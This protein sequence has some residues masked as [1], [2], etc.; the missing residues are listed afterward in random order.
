M[1]SIFESVKNLPVFLT[2]IVPGYITVTVFRYILFNDKDQHKKLSTAIM[3][4]IV[5]SFLIKSIVD[6][7][8]DLIG[9]TVSIASP[10]YIVFMLTL[11]VLL[12]YVSAKVLTWKK[13]ENFLS[14]IGINRTPT[15]NIW[16]DILHAGTWVRIWLPD[17]ERSYLGQVS[18]REDYERAPIVV[19]EQYQFLEDDGTVMYDNSDDD[20]KRVVL[21]L[22]KFERVELTDS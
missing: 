5:I 15:Q 14:K 22:R 11:G 2:Y 21:N 18:Y 7:I 8:A 9:K 1:S 6:W 19:L 12:G 17:S 16:N 4:G 13:T 10:K 3:N 20:S